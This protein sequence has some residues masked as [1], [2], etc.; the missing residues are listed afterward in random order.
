M[1][2]ER[3]YPFLG[4]KCL[5]VPAEKGDC[6]AV[7]PSLIKLAQISEQ[8]NILWAEILKRDTGLKTERAAYQICLPDMGHLALRNK[9]CSFTFFFL[10]LVH[11]GI[12][13]FK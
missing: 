6:P 7:L 11:Q 10:P 3:M 1:L 12:S 9:V 2:L 4:L 8:E 5:N 13:F